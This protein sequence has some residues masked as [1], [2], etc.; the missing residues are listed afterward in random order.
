MGYFHYGINFHNHG[1]ALKENFTRAKFTTYVLTNLSFILMCRNS[2]K[3]YTLCHV[4]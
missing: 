2:W 1:F 4:T 3:R